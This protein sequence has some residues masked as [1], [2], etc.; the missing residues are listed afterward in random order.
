MLRLVGLE[1]VIFK[2]AGTD[3][4]KGHLSLFINQISPSFSRYSFLRFNLNAIKSL[5]RL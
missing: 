4:R 3:G 5:G 2:D 1:I